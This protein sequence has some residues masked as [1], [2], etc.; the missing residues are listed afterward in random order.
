MHNPPMA[1]RGRS[2]RPIPLAG[3]RGF[4]AAARLSSFTLAAAELNLTQSSISRQ[5]RTLETQVGKPLFKRRIR[6]LSLTPAGERFQRVVHA[7]LTEIDRTVGELRRSSQRRRVHVTTF[8]SFA[9][10]MLVPRLPRFTALHPEVDIRIDAVDE[11]R[12]LEADEFDLALRYLPN[13]RVPRDAILLQE[14]EAV[15][16]VSPQLL[17]RIGPISRPE[18]LARATLLVEDSPVQ[19]RGLDGWERWFEAL[20]TAMP[21]DVPTLVL[22]FTYQTLEAALRGQG[23]MLAPVLFVREH[24]AR[25]ELLTPIP[26]RLTSTYG[27]YL[28]RNRRTAAVPHVAGFTQW[29]LGTL[30]AAGQT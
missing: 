11:V 13:D 12:D 4:E 2:T 10:L 7:S 19:L 22:S 5:I 3:L 26:F 27:Y 16:V 6:G 8:A 14:D 28:L 29:L 21:E 30:Q 20:G 25:G 1:S 24:L 9:S 17:A 23:V 15:P 18:D